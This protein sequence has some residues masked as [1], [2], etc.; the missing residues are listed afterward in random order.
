[1]TI[2]KGKIMS[3]KGSWGSGVAYL[4]VD[5][6]DGPRSVPCDNGSTVRAL[7][8]LFGNVI[9]EGHS[10]NNKG[11]HIGQEVFWSYDDMGL[12]LGGLTPVIEAS[13]ELLSLYESEREEG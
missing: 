6:E 12:M 10:I 8:S 13:E 5:C 7:H 4:E 2:H 3:L 1:M 9:G 11:G